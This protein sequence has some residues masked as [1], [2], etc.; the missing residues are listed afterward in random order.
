MTITPRKTARYGWHPDLPDDR[1]LMFDHETVAVKL[2]RKV[3][4][5]DRFTKPFPLDQLQL[6]SCTANGWAA[7]YWFALLAQGLTPFVAS[8]LFIYYCERMMEGSVAQDSGAMIRDGAK[9]LATEGAPPEALWPYDISKFA[10]TPPAP[11]FATG[12]S[13]QALQYLRVTQT[14]KAMKTCLAAGFP[15]VTGFTVYTSFESQQVAQTGVVPMPTRGEKV[16]G[17]HATLCTGYDDDAGTYEELNSWGDMWGD[18]GFFHMP[19]AYLQSSR[20]ASDFWTLRVVE[21]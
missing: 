5:R 13:H 3:S 19:Q 2:P 9:A 7:A 11:V 1:D 10:V 15:F 17:G 12:L 20:L 18:R 14:A 8:R 4:L 21:G 16:L 6:G